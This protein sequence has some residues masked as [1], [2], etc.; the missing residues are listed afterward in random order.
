M[1][2]SSLLRFRKQV[3][4]MAQ[5]EVILAQW[6]RSREALKRDTLRQELH[7]LAHEL[8]RSLQNG[9]GKVFAQ[10][11]LQW[12]DDMRTA[13]ESQECRLQDLDR[14]LE[15]LREKLK[16]THHARRVVEIV[17]AK[18]ESAILQQLAKQEQ[19]SME[20]AANHQHVTTHCGDS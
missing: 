8:D 14:K 5:E 20:E 7:R 9:V 12:V 4:E 3:E 16:K 17:I 1:N 19:R 2:W 18:K 6:E 11:R 10:Q 15:G 13:L